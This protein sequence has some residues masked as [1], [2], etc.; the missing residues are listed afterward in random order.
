MLQYL[1]FRKCLPVDNVADRLS[2]GKCLP[3][4]TNNQSLTCRKMLAAAT[5]VLDS[6]K[7]NL[8]N[9]EGSVNVNI[10]HRNVARAVTW[11]STLGH[12]IPE[13]TDEARSMV[14][15]GEGCD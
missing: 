6:E 5:V 8:C 11:S 12:P 7:I 4:S 3:P 14:L 13:S 10:K 1:L 2:T 15:G 9:G